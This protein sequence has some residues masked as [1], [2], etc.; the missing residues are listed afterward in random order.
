MFNDRTPMLINNYQFRISG[1]GVTEEPMGVFSIGETDGVVSVHKPIDRETYPF[2]H[3]SINTR[4][5]KDGQTDRRTNRQ[6]KYKT[7]DK[8]QNRQIKLS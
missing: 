1:T 5:Q 6:I 2:F 7:T 8:L 3:V 4:R